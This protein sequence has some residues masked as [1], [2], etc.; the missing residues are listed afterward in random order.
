[1]SLSNQKQ[2]YKNRLIALNNSK[3]ELSEKLVELD[4]KYKQANSDFNEYNKEYADKFE[5]LKKETTDYILNI[6]SQIESLAN[7]QIE[8]NSLHAKRVADIKK[9]LVKAFDEY[10]ELVKV[11]P[12]MLKKEDDQ[13]Q[14]AM[15]ELAEEFKNK[16]A[17][18]NDAHK[19]TIDTLNAYKQDTLVNIAKEFEEFV[20]KKDEI[21][22]SYK[23]EIKEIADKYDKLISTEKDKQADLR[24]KIDLANKALNQGEATFKAEMNNLESKYAKDKSQLENLHNDTYAKVKN[25][26]LNNENVANGE[27]NNITNNIETLN[28]KINEINL[29]YDVINDEIEMKK[30]AIVSVFDKKMKEIDEY[31]NNLI[32]DS[33]NK[34]KQVDVLSGDVAKVFKKS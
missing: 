28:K 13:K 5:R 9:D 29:K 23:D 27:I 1:M 16:I 19:Q 25:D 21:V 14:D 18:L 11:K 3:Q 2:E 32:L 17:E 4:K 7:K 24:Y 10:E 33:S 6:K 26:F 22:L 20:S 12:F 34:R 30:F 31:Y 8:Y 15:L